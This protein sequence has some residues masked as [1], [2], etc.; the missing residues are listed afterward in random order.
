MSEPIKKIDQTP[1]SFSPKVKPEIIKMTE[2]MSAPIER[3]VETVFYKDIPFEVVERP[4]VLWVGCL[5]Y[6]PNNEDES[7]IDA[8]LKR[9]RE[10]LIDVTKHERINP[11]WSASLSIN[12]GDDNKPN[13]M[14]FAQET[15]T[16]EQDNRYDLF[17]QPGGLWLR[18]CCNKEANLAL[19]NEE[20]TEMWKYF[21]CGVLQAAAEENGYKEKPSVHVQIE[22]HCHVEYNTPP[23]TCYAYVPIVKDAESYSPKNKPE[24]LNMMEQA[25]AGINL[26]API[27]PAA[28]TI[29]YEKRNEVRI[30]ELPA[31]KMV[32]SGPAKGEDAFAPGGKME[33]FDKWFSAYE[34]QRDDRFY[35]RNFMWSPPGG[36]FQWGYAVDEIPKDIPCTG[37]KTNARAELSVVA[38]G[39]L[40]I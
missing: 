10:E 23:H 13:G 21:A 24:I 7:D 37:I 39:K 25:S 36:G 8:T 9:Y 12:Y 1:E 14:M 40:G 4:D 16:T 38:N 6:A 22:Y 28:S 15:S 32:T 31:C 33:L 26:Q 5:D 29:P 2:R 20:N 30:I 18:L 19:F 3:L 35:P 17:T 34:K 11:D 27:K